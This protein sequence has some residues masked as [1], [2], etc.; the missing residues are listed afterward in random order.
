MAS[1]TPLNSPSDK[2]AQDAVRT[3]DK[4][5]VSRVDRCCVHEYW[6][7]VERDGSLV[8]GRNV[9]RS[10]RLSDGVYEVVF[11]ADVTQGVYLATIGR[12][13]EATEPAGQISVALRCC[14]PPG[15]A[16]KGIWV[17]THDP[18]GTF[19]DR[20]FHLLVLTD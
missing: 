19:S 11:T 3:I 18:D 8:R 2:A 1:K 5:V 15:E 16:G 20:S 12:P 14:L 10:T 17:D 9:V 7:V 4:P 13:G 6:A